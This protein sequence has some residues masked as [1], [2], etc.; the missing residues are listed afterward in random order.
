M[1][2]Y[3]TFLDPPLKS[4]MYM[5]LLTKYIILTSHTVHSAAWS[6]S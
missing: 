3:E 5:L 4:E 6:L 1:R 2:P